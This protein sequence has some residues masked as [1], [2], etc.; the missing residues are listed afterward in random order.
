L[1]GSIGVYADPPRGIVPPIFLFMLSIEE[2]RSRILA[3]L[4]P[5]GLETVGLAV[6]WSRVLGSPVLARLTHPPADVSAMDG[7]AVRAAD[8]AEGARLRVVG[9]APAGRPFDGTLKWGEAVRIFTGSFIPPGADTVVLQEDAT[10]QAETVVVGAT[11][12]V[13]QHIRRQGQDFATGDE[14]IAAGRRLGAREIGLAAAANHPWLQVHRRPRVAILSTGDEIFLPG[15]YIAAGGIVSS[16]SHLLAALVRAAGAEA[17]ILPQAGDTLAEIATAAKAAAGFDMLVTTGGASVGE[18]DLVREGLRQAGFSLDFWK[19]A[20]RPGKPM[21][22][23][24]MGGLPVI[25][26]PGN[27]VSTFVCALLFVVPAIARLAGLP[28]A[29]PAGEAALLG[30]PVRANDHRAD[31]LRAA[32]ERAPDGR[33]MATPFERQDSSLQSMLARSQALIY[34]APHAPALAAGAVVQVIRLDLGGF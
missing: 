34:R 26:L 17:A 23:G 14:V 30:A 10:A 25:G 33:W 19:I 29:A 5:V 7:Y 24:Q 4:A 31:H 2:A 21:M 6:G 20:M 27:P 1:R 16:N 11:P 22:F 3:G 15:E 18:H 28:A 32:L 8:A 9:A 13:G 12:R